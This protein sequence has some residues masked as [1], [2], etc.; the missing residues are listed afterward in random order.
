MFR[1]PRESIRWNTSTGPVAQISSHSTRE[2]KPNSCLPP[3][4]NV[5][6]AAGTSYLPD[7]HVAEGVVERE[8]EHRRS[9]QR[10][11][12]IIEPPERR[13]EK[14]GGQRGARKARKKEDEKAKAPA[15]YKQPQR[16]R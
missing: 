5:I 12:D 16:G 15:K 9:N 10:Y 7:G 1:S 11:R 8:V 2:I 13:K 14:N 4:Q 6:F 3:V